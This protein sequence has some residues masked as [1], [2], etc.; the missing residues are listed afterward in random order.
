MKILI[1]EDNKE[2]ADW[3]AKALRQAQYAVDIAFDGEDAELMRKVASCRRPSWSRTR[4]SS[5]TY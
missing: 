5:R 2:L 1:V 3:L 4:R